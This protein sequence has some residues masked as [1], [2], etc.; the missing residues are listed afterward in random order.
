MRRDTRVQEVAAVLQ[1]V[2]STVFQ[3]FGRFVAVLLVFG[4]I[5]ATAAA[6]VKA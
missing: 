5:T 4:A 2:L 3:F 1:V 6:A